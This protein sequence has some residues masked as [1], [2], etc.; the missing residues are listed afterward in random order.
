MLTCKL[1]PQNPNRRIFNPAV[2]AWGTAC[3]SGLTRV[4]KWKCEIWVWPWSVISQHEGISLNLW[5]AT[6]KKKKICKKTVSA[7]VPAIQSTSSDQSRIQQCCSYGI[8]KKKASLSALRLKGLREPESSQSSAK[9]TR[10][11]SHNVLSAHFPSHHDATQTVIRIKP[12][13]LFA[14]LCCAIYHRWSRCFEAH[15]G[16]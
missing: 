16:I 4:Y 12:G 10:E 7:A 9:Y 1:R 14:F 8:K 6:E 11:L 3:V 13:G 5:F 2:M 15:F